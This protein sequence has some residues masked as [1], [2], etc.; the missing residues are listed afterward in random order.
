MNINTPK[1]H[2]SS[3]FNLNTAVRAQVR[4]TKQ[5]G[6]TA[7]PCNAVT[8]N[9]WWTKRVPNNRSRRAYSRFAKTSWLQ[10]RSGP[11]SFF[12]KGSEG[13]REPANGV[14]PRRGTGDGPVGPP[15]LKRTKAQLGL[16]QPFQAKISE[17]HY[18]RAH[19]S[20]VV[21]FFDS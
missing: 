18:T 20:H 11:A 21:T 15:R 6:S 7:P 16:I 4:V 5:G 9:P 17:R 1:S 13:L 8:S 2:N 3:V 14:L 19:I 12:E 10:P